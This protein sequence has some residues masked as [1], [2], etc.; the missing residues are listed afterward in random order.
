MSHIAIKVEDISKSFKLPIS[1][2]KTL[3]Q[4]LMDRLKGKQG[5][6]KQHVLN[7]I[8]FTVNKG[9]FFGIV[10]RNGSGKST[11]LKIIAQIYSADT[12]KVTV[13]GDVVSFIELGV[14]FNAEL[15]GR[16][17]VYLSCA[18]FGF[19]NQEVDAMYNDIVDF[20]E[21]HDFMDQKLD[22][23]SS[24]MRVRLAFS[25]S[26]KAHGDILILDEV[27]AVGDAAFKEKCH[28]YFMERKQNKDATTILVTHDMN[29]VLTY[30]NK[31][32]LINKG[33]ILVMG[34]PEEVSEKYIE[35]NKKIRE[36]L[37]KEK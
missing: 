18:L 20:A 2:A 6:I 27:L 34:T 36:R 26:I 7:N 13:N 19:S 30:C 28:Q 5:Y 25:V 23:Y 11:L 14:G 22:L 37:L 35:I 10:G 21:L 15:T 8:N 32:L 29:A 9:D 33:D 1:K 16:E 12:G 31:A 24:G 17:N 4:L 3:R